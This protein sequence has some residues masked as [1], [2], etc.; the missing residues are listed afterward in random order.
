M[1]RIQKIL[2]INLGSTSSKFAY[3]EN[4]KVIKQVELKHDTKQLRALKGADDVTAFF[5]KHVN[6]FI[7]D[8]EVDMNALDAIAVRGIGKSGSYHHGAYRLTKELLEDVKGGPVGHVGLYAS[9]VLGGQLAEQYNIPAFLY[10]VVPTDEV[11]DIARI[12][13]IAHY[14]RHIASHTLNCRAVARRVAEEMGKDPAHV[15]FI[16]THM[17]GGFGT[18]AYRDGT[19]VETYSAEEGSFTPERPGRISSNLVAELYSNPKYSEDDIRRILKKDVGLY[20]WLGTS[21]CIEVE[22]RI[23]AGDEKARLVYSAMA[24]QVSKDICS[25]GAVFCGKVDAIILTGGIA[26]SELF[27]GWIEERVGFLAPVKRVPGAFE[28][29]AL[30]G[31]VTRVLNGQEPV[32][33]Y[34]EVKPYSM[35]L[36][37]D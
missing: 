9:T 5:G 32:N 17:G 18:L 34:N 36:E 16:I 1:E 8:A 26:H 27:T 30:A 37:E 10:D 6:D 7:R 15:N 3:C 14:Q 12:T 19:I 31:G 28:I 13:G 2:V 4:D 29:E 21:S 23:A 35:F 33:D 20:G 25:L 11:M 22:Q 24:Y